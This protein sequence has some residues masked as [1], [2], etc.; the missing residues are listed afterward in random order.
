MTSHIQPE[1]S[2]D[3]RLRSLLEKEGVDFN[4]EDGQHIFSEQR[5]FISQA[6]E[7]AVSAERKRIEE[8]VR[9]INT[10]CKCRYEGETVCCHE[11][12]KECESLKVFLAII[13]PKD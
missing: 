4:S 8:A 2:L 7:E 10:D 6:I 9:K 3:E 5:A 13:N 12:C 1:A 11:D